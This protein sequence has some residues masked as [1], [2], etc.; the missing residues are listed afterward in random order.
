VM[1]DDRASIRVLSARLSE[2]AQKFKMIHYNRHSRV[3]MAYLAALAG[4]GEAALADIEACL[5][6]WSEAG[7]RYLL[8][9]VWII[10]IRALL[11]CDKVDE[12]FAAVKRALSH[13][14]ETGEEIFAAELHRLNGIIALAKHVGR[15]EAFAE[16]AFRGAINIAR[17][18][19]AKLFELRATT[20]L[21]RLWRDRG[22]AS[23]AERL[24]APTYGWFTEGFATPDLSEAKTVLEECRA[25]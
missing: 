21:A 7:Y 1:V 5:S 16:Q 12:A 13:V 4:D 14:A 15:D 22:K 10:Q 17:E 2:H 11:L 9:V 20:S 8:P 3:S 6:E 25:S 18:Q 19:G 24:L 23:E